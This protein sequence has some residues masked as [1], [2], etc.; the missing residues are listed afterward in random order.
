MSPSAATPPALILARLDAL[1][2]ANVARRVAPAWGVAP[3]T[4]LER[5]SKYR[6]FLEGRR[7]IGDM[8]STPFF[9][10]LSA[11]GISLAES[12]PCQNPH[13]GAAQ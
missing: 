8:T 5:L 10:L 12:A 13:N 3:H 4:A 1:G 9:A 6:A 11:L 7:H 2:A